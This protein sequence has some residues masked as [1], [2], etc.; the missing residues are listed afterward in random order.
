MGQGE[1]DEKDFEE[2][3]QDNFMATGASK[4]KISAIFL[5]FPL[6]YNCSLFP[7]PLPGEIIV[8]TSVGNNTKRPVYS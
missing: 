1:K 2:S 4:V 8:D 7:T 5:L 6:V 3:T